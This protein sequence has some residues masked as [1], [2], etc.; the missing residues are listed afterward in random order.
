MENNKYFKELARVL[1]KHNIEHGS[2]EMGGLS[3]N[4]MVSRSDLS[5][6]AGKKE[7]PLAC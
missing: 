5:N 7:R 1:K 3:S 2:V 4:W 6:H